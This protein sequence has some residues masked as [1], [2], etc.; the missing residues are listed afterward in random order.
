MLVHLSVDMRRMRGMTLLICVQWLVQQS[1]NRSICW[2]ICVE[3]LVH[4]SY[5]YVLKCAECVEWLVQ[6]VEWLVQFVEWLFQC[7][8]WLCWYASNDLFNKYKYILVQQ[9]HLLCF[10]KYKW[11][12]HQTHLPATLLDYFLWSHQSNTLNEQV[13]SQMPTKG[14]W[15]GF[16]RPNIGLR[17]RIREVLLAQTCTNTHSN[18][19]THPRAIPHTR[20]CRPPFVEK[21]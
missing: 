15:A 10:N 4:V 20:V 17:K 18:I 7:V 14:L 11:L 6:C 9:I 19:H 13:M 16:W 8:E 2:L 21:I 12:V 3:C 5:H 1:S